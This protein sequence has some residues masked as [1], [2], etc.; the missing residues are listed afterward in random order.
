MTF[1]PL[2]VRELPDRIGARQR[3]G[4]PSPPQPQ[5]LHAPLVGVGLGRRAGVVGHFALEIVALP[6]L[7][8]RPGVALVEA[9]VEIVAP[10]P[11]GL[12][13]PEQVQIP[14]QRAL[15]ALKLIRPS[16]SIS[17]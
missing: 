17:S 13:L 11:P 4:S 10:R 1:L 8:H 2:R 12:V 7:L 3:E 14:L 5:R 16:A 9:R 6:G 15:R